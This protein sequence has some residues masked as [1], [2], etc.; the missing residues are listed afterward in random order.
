MRK[1][2]LEKAGEW[3]HENIVMGIFKVIATTLLGTI[4]ALVGVVNSFTDPNGNGEIV[5]QIVSEENIKNLAATLFYISI[6]IVGAVVYPPPPLEMTNEDIVPTPDT[7]PEPF[8]VSK[9]VSPRAHTFS[10]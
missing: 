8:V 1:A 4:G 6:V 7:K 5:N 3:I 10:L 2:G 9:F